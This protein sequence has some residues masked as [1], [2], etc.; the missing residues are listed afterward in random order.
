[1]P[2]FDLIKPAVATLVLIGGFAVPGF[3]QTLPT[4]NQ[5]SEQ[6]NTLTQQQQQLEELRFL[7]DAVQKAYNE[8][9][10]V[11]RE[12]LFALLKDTQSEAGG[13]F[14]ADKIWRNWLASAPSAEVRELVEKSMERRRWYDYDGARTLLNEAIEKAPD[15]SE[16]WNQRAYINFLQEKFDE[17]LEDIEKA[18]ELEPKHFGALSGKARILFHQ[19]RQELAREAL[20]IAV[21][22]HPWMYERFLLGQIPAPGQEP[23]ENK[24]GEEL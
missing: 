9:K 8:D 22:I 19:G 1:M 16:G 13:R 5:N 15:Y 6:P 11:E 18:L 21:A 10:A 7:D 14:V 3:A 17:A 12:R 20:L 4:D 24:A 23:I 2:F